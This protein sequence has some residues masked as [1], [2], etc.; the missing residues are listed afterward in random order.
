MSQQATTTG[1][2][3]EAPAAAGASG[4]VSVTGLTKK[5]GDLEAVRGVDFDVQVGETFGFLGPN[6]AGKSTTR[7]ARAA[8]RG[9]RDCA[10][11]TRRGTFKL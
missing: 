11:A 5:Y 9:R 8:C 1:D 6:G 2:A 10:R 4:A 3:Q 7:L